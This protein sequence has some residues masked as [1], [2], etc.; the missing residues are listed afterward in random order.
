MNEMNNTHNLFSELPPEAF[1]SRIGGS[2]ARLFAG[3]VPGDD[4]HYKEACAWYGALKTSKLLGD[5]STLET[6]AAKY[7][8]FAGTYDELLSGTGHVDNNVFGIVPLEIARTSG[9]GTYLEDG[10]TLA[11]H[12]LAHIDSQIRMAIDDMFMITALQVNAYRASGD[13]RHLDCAASTMALYLQELQQPDGLFFHHRDFHHRWCRGNGW[14][15]AGMAELIQELPEES[16]YASAVHSG[17]SHMM[18]GL[19]EYQIK[20]GPAKGL[21]KQIV[22]SNDPRNWP[23]TSGSAMF[24]F[25]LISGVKKGWLD[26]DVYGAA[27]V[28]AWLGLSR[29]VVPSGEIRNVSKWAYKPFSHPESGDKYD[30][31]EENYYFD[32]EKCLG[33]NHGQAPLMWCAAALLQ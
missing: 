31:D 33:D 8:P 13:D 25:A 23:E 19:L 26:S 10:L 28:N 18:N 24:C 12:Q 17:Y 2:A 5:V 29:F 21:W 9:D 32:R 14:V 16:R 6:L 4:K 15:A 3:S 20:D 11:R 1:P 30:S 7:R 27:A 22:N